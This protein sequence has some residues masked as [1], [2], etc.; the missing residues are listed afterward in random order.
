[1]KE[2]KKRLEK[3]YNECGINNSN[4]I[5]SI[6]LLMLIAGIEEEFMIEIPIEYINKDLVGDI[7]SVI[8]VIK[9]LTD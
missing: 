9:K 2:I 8:S 3:V 4:A 7:D 5:D 6:Q 1:M